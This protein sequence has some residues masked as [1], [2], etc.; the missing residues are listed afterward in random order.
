MA[1]Q[2]LVRPQLEYASAIWDPHT[3]ENAHKIEI[4]VCKNPR[5]GAG[6]PY[7]DT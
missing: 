4:Y 5:H 2:T 6:S 1:C 7:T 3:K